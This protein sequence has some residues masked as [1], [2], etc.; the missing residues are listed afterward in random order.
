MYEF[1]SLATRTNYHFISLVKETLSSWGINSEN[2]LRAYNAVLELILVSW[3]II[4]PPRL[5]AGIVPV[6]PLEPAGID[7][8]SIASTSFVMMVVKLSRFENCIILQ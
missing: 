6:S 2:K 1:H 8:S 4:P 7:G 5:R 3:C